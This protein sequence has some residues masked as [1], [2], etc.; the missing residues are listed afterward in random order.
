MPQVIPPRPDADDRYFWDGVA[1]GKLLLQRCAACKQLRQPPS[2]MCPSCSSLDWETQEASGRAR[3]YSWIVSRHP[4]EADAGP[5]IVVLLDLAE[6]V[7][8]VSNLVET[9]L[10]AVH[11]GLE[12]ELT[13]VDHDGVTLPQFRALAAGGA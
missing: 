6:G 3:V 7:R 10:D 4:T 12:V 5:R 11:H 2:P 8:L 9:P 13:F 1:R